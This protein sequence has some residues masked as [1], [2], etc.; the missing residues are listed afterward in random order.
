MDVLE[1]AP[2]SVI[3]DGIDDLAV[4]HAIAGAPLWQQIRRV[5]HAFHAARD[6]EVAVARFD[7]LRGEHDRLEAR[8]ADLVDG[9]GGNVYRHTAADG[10]LPRGRLSL[11]SG[12][13]VAHNHFIDLA[14]WD[15][16]R[17][18]D[19]RANH[20]RA[21]LRGRKGRERAQETPG[22]STHRA[23]KNGIPVAHNLWLL[24]R[25][26]EISECS[27]SPGVRG[28][29]D[30]AQDCIVHYKPNSPRART[31]FRADSAAGCEKDT[32]DKK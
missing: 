2:E 9:D 31:A 26:P 7:G 30:I 15:T 24:L 17:A 4:A 12:D 8:P 5:A 32:V 20:P 11:A 29:D 23:D 27:L 21:K 22:G 18:F 10:R 19:S 13:D 14:G 3:D 28:M 6:I 25:V 1:G 16:T